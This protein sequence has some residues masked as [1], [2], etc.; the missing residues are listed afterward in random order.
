MDSYEGANQAK[1][2]KE[3]NVFEASHNTGEVVCDVIEFPEKFD[4]ILIMMD[5]YSADVWISG[6]PL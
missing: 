5:N 6:E 2:S 1:N 3:L 4:H